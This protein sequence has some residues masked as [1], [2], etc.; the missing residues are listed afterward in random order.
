MMISRF[1]CQTFIEQ[2]TK[3]IIEA[4][5]LQLANVFKRQTSRPRQEQRNAT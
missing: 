1:T 2:V 5:M 4:A 3:I